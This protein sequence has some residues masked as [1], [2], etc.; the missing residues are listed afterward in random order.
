MKQI[1]Q[2]AK[3]ELSI[4]FFSPIAWLVIIIFAF[5]SYLSFTDSL[6]NMLKL[7]ETNSVLSNVT[8]RLFTGWGAI[9]PEV[10]KYLYLYIPLVSMGLLSRE[11]NSGSIKLLYSSPISVF[12]IIMGKFLSMMVYSLLL[13]AILIPTIVFGCA[14][15]VHIDFIF[16]LSGIVV[17]NDQK[18]SLN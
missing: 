3:N 11:Y 5:Q 15:I 1:L 9:Y 2:I 17:Q 16:L 18:N 7:Q 14:T 13:I 12:Q 4:L 10:Q 6:S 8:V